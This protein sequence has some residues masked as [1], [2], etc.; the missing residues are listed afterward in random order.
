VA[1]E[2]D[3]LTYGLDAS[4]TGGQPPING[5]SYPRSAVPFPE[6]IGKLIAGKIRI[7]NRG[8]P[9]DSSLDGLKRWRSAPMAA[10]VFIMYGTNDFGNFGHRP[11]GVVD[12]ASFKVAL[13]ELVLRRKNSG[14]QVVLM[15]PPPTKDENFDGNLEDYRRVIRKVG[16]EVGATVIESADIIR[17]VRSKWTDG[18]HLS[19]ESN[20][21]LATSVVGMIQICESGVS[22]A[23]T[24]RCISKIQR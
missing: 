24:S 14:A 7:L 2:G 16:K 20:Q 3:S 22:A 23:R 8:Y 18:L 9:G 21:A 6:E 12:L 17:G 15:T 1:F 19:L 11:D 4:E 5:S 13:Q 10:L